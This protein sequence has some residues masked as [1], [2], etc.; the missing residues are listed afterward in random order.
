MRDYEK[1]ASDDALR[2]SDQPRFSEPMLAKR[3]R[4]R[5]RQKKRKQGGIKGLFA[6]GKTLDLLSK[7]SWAGL[8]I[9]VAIFL[10]THLVIVGDWVGKSPVQAK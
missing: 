6:Q 7:A 2:P 10:L 4:E 1:S 5:L 8:F 3:E 9:L